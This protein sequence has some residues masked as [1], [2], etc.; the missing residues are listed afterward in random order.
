MQLSEHFTLEELTHTDHR[1]FDNTPNADEIANLTR[2]ASFLEEVKT[3]LGGSTKGRGF[4]GHGGD[5]TDDDFF[6]GLAAGQERACED[7][8]DGRGQYVRLHEAS[9]W[10][11]IVT[12]EDAM[13]LLR[14]KSGRQY[15]RQS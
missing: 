3:V 10:V 14:V 7:R 8:G 11:W 2:L 6:A 4:A 1:E 13:P 15:P 5:A 9:L 12:E